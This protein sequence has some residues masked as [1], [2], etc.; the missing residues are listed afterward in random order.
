MRTRCPSCGSA[1]P[2]PRGAIAV[3]RVLEMIGSLLILVAFFMPWF[4]VQRLIMTG[5]F[6]NDFLASTRDLRQFLPGFAGGPAEVT[7]LRV[8]VLLFPACGAAAALLAVVGAVAPRAGRILDAGAAIAGLVALAALAIG[9][10]RL[11]AGAIVHV[12]LWLI[13]AGGAAILAGA[14]LDAAMERAPGPS[15]QSL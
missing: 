11:P 6:L 12:G 4:E 1:V 3:G 10:T 15:R 8:L 5:E 2:A 14:G 9:V 7:Q 13:G